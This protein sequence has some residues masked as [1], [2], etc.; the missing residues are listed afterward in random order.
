MQI[1]VCYYPHIPLL[2]TGFIGG[3]AGG[4][5]GATTSGTGGAGGGG[6]TLSPGRSSLGVVVISFIGMSSDT[7]SGVTAGVVYW[8][9]YEDGVE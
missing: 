4:G 9:S 7:Q 2:C 5:G 3:G 8:E 1:Q 6:G